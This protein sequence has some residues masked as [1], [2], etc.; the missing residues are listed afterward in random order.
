MAESHKHNL[1]K[2]ETMIL[3]KVKMD[4]TNVMLLG[5]KMV[6]NL[7]VIVTAMRHEESLQ[8]IGNIQFLHL[9]VGYVSIFS[10]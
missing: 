9:Q 3:Y 2:V 7:Q 1:E 10:A 6:V 5:N 4:K 8:G